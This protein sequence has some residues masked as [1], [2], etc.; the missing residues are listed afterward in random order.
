MAVKT[1]NALSD[2]L[3]HFASIPECAAML[4]MPGIA[5]GRSNRDPRQLPEG[6]PPSRDQFFK[7]LMDND[8]AVPHLLVLYQDPFFF[9]GAGAASDPPDLPFLVRSVS[10][11][12]DLRAGLNGWNG[13]VHGGFIAAMMD[14]AMGTLIFQNNVCNLEAKSESLIPS[15]AK[16]FANV[17]H[18]TGRMEV[19][20]RQPLPSPRVVVV[21]AALDRIEGRKVKI[22][23]VVK[24]LK[25]LQYATG[26]GTW[27]SVP[28]GK[29]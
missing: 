16:D 20:Y 1:S 22:K 27:I 4:Q 21:T 18:V 12:F 9:D 19:S 11:L 15:S 23:V 28:K 10:V 7:H 3:Q 13:T 6:C 17:A 5:L 2:S 24:D 14:E 25:G 26:D 8:Q 29:L